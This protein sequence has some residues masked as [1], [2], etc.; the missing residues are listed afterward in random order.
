MSKSLRISG[1]EFGRSRKTQPCK[2]ER[3]YNSSVLELS[4]KSYHSPYSTLKEKNG[5][6]D[7]PILIFMLEG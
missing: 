2:I 3:A 6:L 1:L 4:L 5:E 7:L